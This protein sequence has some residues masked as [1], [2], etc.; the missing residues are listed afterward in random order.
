MDQKLIYGTTIFIGKLDIETIYGQFKTYTYQN[1][2]NKNYIIALC[3]GD[4]KN[5]KEIYCRLHSS[6]ITSETLKSQDCDCVSQLNKALEIIS[7]KGG[8]VF[9][10]LQEG[11]GCGYVG[12]SR[13]C[14]LVQY[15]P[16]LDT[17]EAYSQLGMKKDYRKY[18]SIRDIVYLLDLK[19]KFILLTNNPDK[20]SGLKE[21]GIDIVRSERIEIPSNNYNRHYLV[22]KRKSGHVLNSETLESEINKLPSKLVKPFQPYNVPGLKR[23]IHMSS[24]YL[25]IG[26][27]NNKVAV[28]ESILNHLNSKNYNKINGKIIVDTSITD[29]DVIQSESIDMLWFKVSVYFDLVN[30][31]EF[32]ILEYNNLEDDTINN[33]IVR[34]H[35]EAIFNRFPLKF[36]KNKI[37]YERSLEH[38]IH[39]GKGILILFYKDGRGFGLGNFVLNKI[40]SDGDAYNDRDSRDYDSV[41]ILLKHILV[42]S[43]NDNDIDLCISCNESRHLATTSLNKEHININRYIYIG[44]GKKEKGHDS[45][46]RRN[47]E[48]YK[49]L[50]K[51]SNDTQSISLIEHNKSYIV[52]GMGS[53][54]TNA[55]YLTYLLNTY[56]DNK[57]SIVISISDILEEDYYNS[58]IILFSQGLSPHAKNVLE[59]YNKENILLI[60][61]NDNKKITDQHINKNL[62]ILSLLDTNNERE[63]LLRLKGPFEGFINSLLIIKNQLGVNL[64][65][66]AD[67]LILNKI[68]F[69]K[70]Y[71]TSLPSENFT[72]N[73]IKK[74]SLLIIVPSPIKD[75]IDNIQ[76]KFV[77]GCGI[78]NCIVC[79]PYEFAHGK[80][81]A[82][83]FCKHNNNQIYSI[84]LFGGS[85][86]VDNQTS[87]IN[88]ILEDYP[89]WFITSNLSVNLKIL[90]Y[91]L[92]INN[93]II[94]LINRLEIDQ[95]NWIG[96]EK[97]SLIYDTVS[98]I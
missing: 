8:I 91:E 47:Y 78:L 1:V 44:I 39:N 80:Y 88:T 20:I 60:T 14:M 29:L 65:T 94:D 55:K 42:S 77:E 15:N 92:I 58:T 17:F 26:P 57:K 69:N 28:S 5:F 83:E 4:I 54:F 32:V 25:P 13:S 33:T 36:C 38:I 3:S 81:Q 18:D 27:I 85:T 82:L 37:L 6:C 86:N 61:S 11:R 70:Q 84:I 16:K 95:V 35:S 75:F 63:T 51:L 79:D 2:I 19:G 68:I 40:A 31:N 72:K 21:N 98:R 96:K 56:S 62:K 67:K 87:N 22:S 73:L 52:T 7:K 41:A 10:L 34:I 74:R 12:K 59:K 97:Q 90:H 45:L 64:I 66:E 30:Q 53:S 49:M 89:V 50:G 43:G 24:Y 93:Y 9:Y 23:F 46:E 76:M 71:N 48:C